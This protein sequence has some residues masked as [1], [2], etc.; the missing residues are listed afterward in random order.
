MGMQLSTEEAAT[1]AANDALVAQFKSADV[2]VFVHPMHNFGLPGV[3]KLYM[4]A[5][6]LNGETFK[7]GGKKIPTLIHLNI[8]SLF[9]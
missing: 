9:M 8:T 7:L 3:V 6:E 4:D 2:V 5:V 1:L